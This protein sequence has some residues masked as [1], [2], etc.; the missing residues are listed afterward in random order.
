M[1][2]KPLQRYV[3]QSVKGVIPTETV[4]TMKKHFIGLP[5]VM[6]N[7]W[8]GWTPN[9]IFILEY[10]NAVTASMGLN[11]LFNSFID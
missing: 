4:G 1:Q 3:T 6:L 5:I 10:E 2:P 7:Q 8:H 11:T 9:I